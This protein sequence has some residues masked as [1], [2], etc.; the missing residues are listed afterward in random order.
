LRFGD[1]RLAQRNGTPD[2]RVTFRFGGGNVGI[3]LD[4]GHI[5][6]PHVGDVLILVAHLFDGERNHLQPHLVHVV[7]AGGTHPVGNH[8]GLLHNLFHC[9]LADDAA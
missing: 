9:E 8:F 2:G 1:R 5:W 4:A 7:G 3:A 6:P